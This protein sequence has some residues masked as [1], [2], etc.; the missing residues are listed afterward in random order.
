MP[1]PRTVHEINVTLRNKV[2]FGCAG[3]FLIVWVLLLDQVGW[4]LSV[5]D[6]M[7]GKLFLFLAI[8]LL[9]I[10]LGVVSYAYFYIPPLKG[11]VVRL[12][13]SCFSLAFISMSLAVGGVPDLHKIEFT[14][15]RILVDFFEP[16]DSAP[17]IML[18]TV[19]V[20]G[21]LVTGLFYIVAEMI[22][23]RST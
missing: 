12:A 1:L 18:T 9:V 8:T 10:L 20:V 17:F 19:C 15:S 13:G 3:L 7:P 2:I 6:A 11:F 21:L 4:I 5:F 22:D 23:A 16:K 14:T